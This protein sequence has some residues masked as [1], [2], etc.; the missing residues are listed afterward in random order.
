MMT[1]MGSSSIP[2]EMARHDVARESAF[3]ARERQRRELRIERLDRIA[4]QRGVFADRHRYYAHELQRVMRGL[5]TPGSRVLEVGCGLGDLLASLVSDKSA[6]EGVG[7][8]ISPRMI[9][10]ARHRHPQ[11]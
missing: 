6:G 7:I 4:E 2:P 11:L 1:Q 10:R 8:D 9:E 5:I 3:E